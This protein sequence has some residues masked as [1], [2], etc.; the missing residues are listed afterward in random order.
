LLFCSSAIVLWALLAL[1]ALDGEIRVGGNR[2]G[3]VE[4]VR[5]DTNPDAFFWKVA[6]SGT[7]IGVVGVAGAFAILRHLSANRSRSRSR[8]LPASDRGT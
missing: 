3:R 1:D 2:G 4:V 5:R 6:W 8:S 7:L